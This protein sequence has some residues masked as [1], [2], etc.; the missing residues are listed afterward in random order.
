MLRRKRCYKYFKPPSTRRTPPPGANGANY[1]FGCTPQTTSRAWGTQYLSCRSSLSTCMMV[2]CHHKGAQPIKVLLIITFV[3]PSKY[4]QPWGLAT[5][6]TKIWEISA[7]AWDNSL[8]RT[9]RNTLLLPKCDSSL[10]PSSNNS[11]PPYKEGQR[12]NDTLVT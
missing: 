6:G 1:M 2:L 8:Q 7:F 3:P 10:S 4:S 11:T 5:P 12:D 9:Q